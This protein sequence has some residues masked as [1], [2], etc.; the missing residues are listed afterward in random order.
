MII[1]MTRKIVLLPMDNEVDGKMGILMN[2][3]WRS[4]FLVST[5][6]LISNLCLIRSMKLKSSLMWPIFMR[7]NMSNL[8]LTNSKE[9]QLHGVLSCKIF[10]GNKEKHLWEVGIRWNN[11]CKVDFFFQ[12]INTYYSVNLRIAERGV[13]LSLLMLKNS[14]DFLRVVNW[15]CRKQQAP[16]YIDGLKYTI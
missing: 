16:K 5:T 15:I 6:I 14:I 11:C 13:D 1:L 8:W 10:E 4:Q 2:V 7:R 3:G 12:N 9:G